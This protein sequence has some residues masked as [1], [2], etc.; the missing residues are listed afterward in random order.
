MKFRK[1]LIGSVGIKIESD[2]LKVNF[3]EINLTP[4]EIDAIMEAY[5]LKKKY[6]RLRSGSF[7]DVGNREVDQ[8]AQIME[9][10][11]LGSDAISSG[12]VTTD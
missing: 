7:I 2:L 6:Y 5:H 4:E 10:L 3:E 12:E 11:R 1:P 9:G 8:L